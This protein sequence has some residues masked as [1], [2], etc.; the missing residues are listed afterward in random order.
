MSLEIPMRVN[1]EIEMESRRVGKT[2][3]KLRERGRRND[4]EKNRAGNKFFIIIEKGN[5]KVKGKRSGGAI[6]LQ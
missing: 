6:P 2:E 4:G 3:K 1:G 5:E